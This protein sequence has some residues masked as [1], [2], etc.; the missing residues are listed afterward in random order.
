MNKIETLTPDAYH[1]LIEKGTEPPNSGKYN[2]FDAKGTYLCR[3][4]GLGLFRSDS[5]FISSCGWP[6]FDDELPNAIK[7]QIDADGR[8]TEI[9]CQRCNSH[10]G[11]VFHGEGYTN[12]NLRHCVNSLSV[13]FVYDLEVTDTEEAIIAGGCFWGVEHLLKQKDG[14]LLTE[15]GYTGG[16]TSNPSYESV[17]Q[18][19]TG[20]I[21]AVRVVF[22]PDKIT[23]EQVIKLFLEI[24]DPT[25]VNG[26]GPDIGEQYRSA[27]FYY[28]NKQKQ[29]AEK[30]LTTLKDKGLS[31]VT[32][33]IEACTFWPAEDY[34]Q[35]YY[36][37]TNK[38]PYCHHYTK[39]FD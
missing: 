6:S 4:C 39:R 15:V 20:H 33:L 31:P 14:I 21:E 19:S 27:I 26:Q 10:L 23:Y 34:H 13:E 17:C 7:R 11:H 29:I 36:L 8:R 24:H 32:L 38:A 5:K 35:D 22:D 9:L 12:K 3:A 2:L 1:I 28:D 25:Q 16:H 18:G 30:L 37:K